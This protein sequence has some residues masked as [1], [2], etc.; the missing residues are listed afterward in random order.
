MKQIAIN[1]LVD[2]GCL[3][4]FIPSV[5]SGLVLY[6]VLPSGGGRGSGW[7]LFLDIPRSQWV[8]MHDNSSLVFAALIIIHLL[9][10]W[11]FFRHINRYFTRDTTSN[12]QSEGGQQP[13]NTRPT[14]LR[15]GP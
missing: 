6:L 11:K 1:A 3:I 9:L 13:R 8:V 14:G 5:I 4:T 10:H 7:E 2:I 15:P 12:A